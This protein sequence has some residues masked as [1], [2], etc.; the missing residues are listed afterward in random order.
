MLTRMTFTKL[1]AS[2][3]WTMPGKATTAVCLHTVKQVLVNHTQWYA[4]I[5]LHIQIGY[6]PNIGIV[7][8][9]CN[10][11]FTRIKKLSNATKRFEVNFSMLEI[12]NEKVQDLLIDPSKR[13]AGGLKIREHTTLGVYV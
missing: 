8:I 6:G 10:E 1:Q 2:K 4:S 5:F 11:I 7:P 3:F 12:Y 13:E 9:A